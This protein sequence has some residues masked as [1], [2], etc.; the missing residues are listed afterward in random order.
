MLPDS[1]KLQEEEARYAN[2]KGTSRH[3]PN[4]LPLYDAADAAA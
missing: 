3:A 1:A 2:A 4:A